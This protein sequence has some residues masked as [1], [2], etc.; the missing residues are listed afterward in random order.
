M[1][2]YHSAHC[3]Q[4]CLHQDPRELLPLAE[5]S[6]GIRELFVKLLWVHLE[7]EWLPVLFGMVLHAHGIWLLQVHP[8]HSASLARSPGSSHQ[9]SPIDDL[10]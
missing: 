1:C 10:I 5:A 3:W 4:A 6:A 9:Y 2:A 8:L 7:D